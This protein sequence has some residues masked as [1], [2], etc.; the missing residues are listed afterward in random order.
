VKLWEGAGARLDPVI[1]AFTVG[2]DPIVDLE[3]VPYD[4]LGTAA[5]A[6]ALAR[7]GVLE[8]GEVAAL[9]EALSALRAEVAAG[10][11]VIDPSEE[12]GHTAIEHRLAARLGDLG[13]KVHAGRSRNDQVATALRLAVRDRLHAMAGAALD[14]AK[15]LLA[16]AR[17]ERRTPM[18]GLSHTRKAMPTTVTHWLAATIEEIL[19]G[20]VLLD[21]ALA[22]NDRCPLGSAAGFGSRLPLDREFEAGILGFPAVHRNT[23]AVQDS[24]GRVEAAALFAASGLLWPCARFA[25]DLILFTLPEVGWFSLPGDLCTG[26]SLMPHKRNPDVLELIRARAAQA[27][28]RLTEVMAIASGLPSGYNRDFQLLKSPTLATLRDATGTLRATRVVADRMTV[29][30]RQCRDACGPEMAATDAVL[31][32]VQRGLPFRDAYAAVK[33]RLGDLGPFDPLEQAMTAGSTG[34][35]GNPG[36]GSLVREIAV[37]SR[38]WIGR[39]NRCTAALRQLLPFF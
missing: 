6:E 35:P 39:N 11:F 32:E 25:T 1:E 27:R 24:R 38:R 31:A 16:R 15:A 17:S 21:A 3:L 12:D 4:L 29:N 34:A 2:D 14:L 30:R 7:C 26:S 37:L 8:P 22:L 10:R 20:M 5:H 13:R 19:D 9:K 23:L 18:P 33:A 28:G 36:L